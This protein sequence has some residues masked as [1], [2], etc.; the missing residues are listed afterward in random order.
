MFMDAIGPGGHGAQSAKSVP[1]ALEVCSECFHDLVV[2]WDGLQHTRYIGNTSCDRR[3]NSNG[4]GT[5]CN[6]SRTGSDTYTDTDLSV[7]VRSGKGFPP[8]WQQP[9]PSC[10]S[11]ELFMARE[12]RETSRTG[13]DRTGQRTATSDS[14]NSGS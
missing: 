12:R 3:I 4:K 2:P 11:P 14:T 9:V 10:S 1:P 5:A 13:Q 6:T 7:F 8:L